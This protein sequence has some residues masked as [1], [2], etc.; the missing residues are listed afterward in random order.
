MILN[1]AS[2]FK[3]RQKLD[4]T[5]RPIGASSLQGI[6][7]WKEKIIA[8]DSIKGYLLQIDPFTDNTTILNP[9]RDSDLVGV[10]GLALA[11]ETLW[12]TLQSS[13]YFCQIND[14]LNLQHFVDLPYT[15]NGIAVK[16]STVY[17]TCKK[18]GYIIIYSSNTGHEIT[19]LRSPGVGIEHI[20]I[21]DEELWVSDDQEQTVYCLD[22]ATG[23]IQFS[24]LTPFENPTGL[25]FCS[26]PQT[27]DDTLYVAYATEEAY[28]RDNP[29][30][31]PNYELQYRDRTFIH[32]LHFTYNPEGRYALSNGYLI[33][34]S[35]VE[36][37]D[38]L[39]DIEL[40][41]LE[42]RIALP[43]ETDR[44]KVSKV[45]PV[46]IPFTID[47]QD[48]QQVAVFKFDNLKPGERH[49]FGWKALLEVWSIKYRL[50]PRDMEG[51][52]ELAPEFQNRYL[53]DDDKLAMDTE[54]IRRSAKEA[55]GSETNLLRQVYSIR[56][57]VYDKLSYHVTPKIDTPDIVLRRGVGSCGEYLG[58][59][60]ALGR[61]NGIA[62][63]TVGRY[64][65]PPHPDQIG[66]PLVPDFNH[67]WMEFYIPGIGWLP[68]E[69]SADDT[70]EG[71]PYPT[72]FL[73]GLAWY[74]IEIGKG[75][76]F[77]ILKSQGVP[78]KKEDISIG[79]LAINHVRFKI[80]AE[81]PSGSASIEQ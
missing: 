74:H 49:I 63:R 1:S 39:K 9:E 32:P 75:I 79:E 19:R 69:S 54:I 42:W 78:V 36:E 38:P 45:E 53:V 59:L 15:A 68:M 34:M 71:G 64:K 33:E 17:V 13:V 62:C 67:V 40:N 66:I 48:G 14:N 70:V 77:E 55:I 27:G 47:V 29:N 22:R 76:K 43:S 51:L 73:M 56:N 37:L 5:I 41:D 65:C 4:K 2:F 25:A 20:T 16:D 58:V 23:E 21:R 72:R 10:T 24:V 7:F 80:L 57:Y 28:I 18:V 44:Q 52:P 31:D 26:D 81:L 3:E 61:L 11:G 6:A 12:L 35:Y 30:A 50:T 46:G 60:L 8:I